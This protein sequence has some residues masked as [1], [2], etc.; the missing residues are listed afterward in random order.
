[1]GLST[2]PAAEG[3]GSENGSKV[4]KN[5][6]DFGSAWKVTVWPLFALAQPVPQFGSAGVAEMGQPSA[7]NAIVKTGGFTTPGSDLMETCGHPLVT[8]A[9]PAAAAM[10]T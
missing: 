5:D 1:M 6:G 4:T 2:L 3:I 9:S 8:T 10:P 7:P